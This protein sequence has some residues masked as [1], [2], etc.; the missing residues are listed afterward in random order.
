MAGQKGSRWDP[1]VSSLL[2]AREDHATARFDAEIMAAEAEGR[3]D[4]V[5][6]R[7]LRWWQR[8]SVRSVEDHVRQVVPTV[9]D[10]LQSADLA[11][12]ESVA[13][14]AE[15]WQHAQPASAAVGAEH[16]AVAPTPG[17]PASPE[18]PA[19]DGAPLGTVTP[20]TPRPDHPGPGFT[21]H[22]APHRPDE[23][24]DGPGATPPGAAPPRLLASGLTVLADTPRGED[25]PTQDGGA[26]LPEDR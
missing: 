24:I 8:Q 3:V 13:E 5:T 22:L 6:A 17:P 21:S 4:A 14:A 9:L 2:D 12:R 10:T 26:A 11:A 16:V 23:R 19:D 25:R 18:D 20:L 15:A 7:T 1:V